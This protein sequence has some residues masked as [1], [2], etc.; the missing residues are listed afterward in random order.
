MS[1]SSMD[2]VLCALQIMVAEAIA[3]QDGAVEADTVLQDVQRMHL[4]VLKEVDWFVPD[5]QALPMVPE[6]QYEPSL[7]LDF[8]VEDGCLEPL[9]MSACSTASN[10]PRSAVCSP[11]FG[12]VA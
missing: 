2:V 12:I 3:A 11:R 9:A 4:P 10:T 1:V 5:C 7:E 8:D 6:C